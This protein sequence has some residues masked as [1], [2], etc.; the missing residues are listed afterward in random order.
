MESL[1]KNSASKA[2]RLMAGSLLKNYRPLVEI[3][4]LDSEGNILHRLAANEDI[5][6]RYPDIAERNKFFLELL[7]NTSKNLAKKS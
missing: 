4:L 2:T 5:M 7:Q 1:A 3:S 6:N